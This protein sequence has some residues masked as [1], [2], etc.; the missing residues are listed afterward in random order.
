MTGLVN[1]DNDGLLICRMLFFEKI[2]LYFLNNAIP[3]FLIDA[4]ENFARPK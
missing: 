2:D 1:R 4:L 3:I